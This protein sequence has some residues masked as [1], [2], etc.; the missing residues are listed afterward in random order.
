MEFNLLP[1]EIQLKIFSSLRI[2]EVMRIRLVCKQWADLLNSQI[3]F[4]RMTCYQL[5]K[6]KV[7]HSGYDFYFAS[8][9]SFGEYASKDSKLSQVKF[10]T[11]SLIM[12]FSE[13]ANAFDLLNSFKSL[14]KLDF[15][16]FLRADSL[17][18]AIKKT[19]TVSLDRLE[20]VKYF[21][22]CSLD[23]N[24]N[25]RIVLDLPR[26]FHLQ[27]ESLKPFDIV[28]PKNIRTLST[29]RLFVGNVDYSQFTGL[30]K[31]FANPKEAPSISASFF[32]RIPTLQELHL[33]EDRGLKTIFRDLNVTKELPE[34][35]SFGKAKPR[36]FY[37]GFEL[38][39]KQL[40]D[41]MSLG[42]FQF[43]AME[44]NQ[45]FTK[46]VTKNLHQSVDKNELVFW[47]HYDTLAE[48]LDDT[49]MFGSLFQKISKI[50]LLYISDNVADGSRLLKFLTKFQPQNIFFERASLP[51]PF[52]RKLGQ[53]GS[54]IRTL[55][56]KSKVTIKNLAEDLD[57]ILG[58]TG[59]H[60]ICFE[61]CPFSLNFVI[62][63]LK[64]LKS[65]AFD[66][67]G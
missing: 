38:T 40:I 62:R 26:L 9:V 34:S 7:C 11:A 58:L 50:N 27:V 43:Q 24:T 12:K 48:E 29:N 35:P 13:L 1:P 5:D 64:G 30:T 8:T 22:I 52:F 66:R 36:I 59:L 54:F 53:D 32:E 23:R 55:L 16:C 14:E 19:F 63:A 28:F 67:L 17:D 33:D 47:L 20:K 45:N 31:I 60:T 4:K 61:N 39:V 15:N 42:Q 21:D 65:R 18:P 25:V 49:A 44:S 10:L 37:Y 6:P 51:Q 3:K 41:Q 46:F 56:I 57:F 2:R